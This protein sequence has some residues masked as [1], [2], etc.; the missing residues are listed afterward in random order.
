MLPPA[1]VN[2]LTVL[3]FD[4]LLLILL[5]LLSSSTV[6]IDD[7]LDTMRIFRVLGRLFVD[8]VT[9]GLSSSIV[10]LSELSSFA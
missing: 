10:S 5:L 3:F 2:R 6:S 8:R 4:G 7:P 9:G 1:V